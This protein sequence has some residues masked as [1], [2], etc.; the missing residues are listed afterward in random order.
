MQKVLVCLVL[1]AAGLVGGLG[2]IVAIWVAYFICLAF[3]LE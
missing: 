3:G 2:L 1:G